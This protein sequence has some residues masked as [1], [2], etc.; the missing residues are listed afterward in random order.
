[1]KS[2]TVM[3]VLRKFGCEPDWKN[4]RH[5]GF[6]LVREGEFVNDEKDRVDVFNGDASVVNKFR[7]G[8]EVGGIKRCGRH[9]VKPTPERGRF[10]ELG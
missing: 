9:L 1:M 4:G 2:G 6:G 7:D 8:C 3:V 10:R 5:E